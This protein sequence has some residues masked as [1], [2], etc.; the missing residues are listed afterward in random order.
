MRALLH[1]RLVN[2]RTG[3]P[4]LYIETLFEKRAIL[5]D[6]GD[7]SPLSPRDVQRLD[8]VFVSHTH[9]D[10]LI[11]FDRLLRLLVGRDKK[12]ALYG[13]PG[14]IANVQNKAH[15]Y[16]W[17][18]AHR[19]ACDLVFTVTE[20]SPRL[21]TRTVRLRLNTAFTARGA[22]RRPAT[23]NVICEE[24]GFRSSSWSSNIGCHA[25]PLRSRKAHINIWARLAEMNLPV[26]PWLRQLK[27]AVVRTSRTT[28]RAGFPSRRVRRSAPNAVGSAALRAHGHAGQKDRLRYRRCRYGREPQSDRRPCEDRGHIVHRGGLCRS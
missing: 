14:F 21:D 17:N 27:Q 23:D 28:I 19:Y 26:G 2:G 25:S 3:D 6:L 9:I 5:F 12:M 15:G 20:I 16:C 7:I 1:P 22:R 18:L 11:G 13:P 4:A 8:H 10:K 24:A